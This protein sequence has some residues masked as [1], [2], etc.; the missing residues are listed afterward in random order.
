MKTNPDDAMLDPYLSELFPTIYYLWPPSSSSFPTSFGIQLITTILL[1][2][3]ASGDK[4]SLTLS[5]PYQLVPAKRYWE[6][7]P[8]M[9]LLA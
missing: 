5:D 2:N 3:V 7:T 4:I 6:L 9:G 8:V 1:K